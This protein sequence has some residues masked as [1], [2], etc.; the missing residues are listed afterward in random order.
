MSSSKKRKLESLNDNEEPRKKRSKWISASE[1]SNCMV[2]NGLIDW[3][4]LYG[5]NAGF[6]EDEP[7]STKTNIFSNF[8]KSKG[9]H[10]EQ[11]VIEKLSPTEYINID[12]FHNDP[13]MKGKYKKTLKAMKEGIPLIFQGVVINKDNKTRGIPDILIRSDYLNNLV[14]VPVIDERESNIG[15]K[16]SNN[17]HY[18]VI[19]IKFT[20]LNLTADLTHILNDENFKKYKGQLWIYNEA[21]GL[22]QEELPP[23]SYILGR[24][25]K[26]TKCKIT[27]SN[28]DSFDK[29]GVIDY[30]DKDEDYIEYTDNA[31]NLLREI[32]TKGDSWD[33]MNIKEINTNLLPNMCSNA[34]YDSPWRSAKEQIANELNEI[35]LIP[36]C[37]VKERNKAHENKIYSW[38]D[39]ECTSKNLGINGKVI[40]KRVDRV[41]EIN[42]NTDP[43]VLYLPEKI[44][45]TNNWKNREPLEI[46]IDFEMVNHVM[47]DDFEIFPKANC[48]TVI[49]MIGILWI[50]PLTNEECTETFIVDDLSHNSE[51]RNISKFV[52][53]IK[54]LTKEYKL[55]IEEH[56]IKMF[57]W[58]HV[59][60]SSFTSA[61]KRHNKESEWKHYKWIDF[62]DI[63]KKEPVGI[64]GLFSHKL[65]DV[66]RVMK[67]HNMIKSSWAET[68]F[69]S[70]KNVLTSI[71]RCNREVLNTGTTLK[72]H[73]EVNEIALYNYYDCKVM[74]EIIEFFR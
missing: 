55:N 40:S 31:V 48:G 53:F 70:G 8:L 2:Q 42:R 25:W 3:L 21:L 15:C 33:I 64:K 46:F 36:H 74:Y 45:N 51:L 32:K 13:D 20:T 67:Q 66:G 4:K 10:F 72:D 69:D 9:K 49:Y 29:L 37:G 16:F 23:Q 24:R 57:H 56:D 18:R 14:N 7:D 39:P 26:G 71:T 58:G 5:N 34:D 59:E 19:D 38:K 27:Y 30:S 17:W 44:N 60:K 50:N 61:I 52:Q 65:K 6:K 63:L 54:G 1:I 12:S 11:K 35:T 62:C 43:N 41:L 73:K 68:G 22:M 28:D 47:F